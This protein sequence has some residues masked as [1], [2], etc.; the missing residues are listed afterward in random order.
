[1]GRTFLGGGV[2]NSWDHP[3]LTSPTLPTLLKQFKQESRQKNYKMCCSYPKKTELSS[4]NML[5]CKFHQ[6]VNRKSVDLFEL[7]L[8]SKAHVKNNKN[9]AAQAL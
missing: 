2:A 9:C 3:Y 8:R 1:M 4:G 6:H 5:F 7:Y